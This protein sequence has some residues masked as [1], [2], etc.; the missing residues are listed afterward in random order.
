M[1]IIVLIDVALL[2]TPSVILGILKND[3]DVVLVSSEM[4]VSGVYIPQPPSF[5]LNRINKYKLTT[6]HI[7]VTAPYIFPY[8]LLLLCY[9][10]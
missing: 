6:T 1:L 10:N 9:I 2:S 8:L 5:S 4:D 3:V 7:D